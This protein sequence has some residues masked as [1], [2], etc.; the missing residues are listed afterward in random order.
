[1]S[2][3]KLDKLGREYINDLESRFPDYKER[4]AGEN[5]VEEVK[6]RTPNQQ[7]ILESSIECVEPFLYRIATSLL[8]GS[9][10][11]FKGK[12]LSL[13]GCPIDANDLVAVGVEAI[14]I[15][16]GRYNPDYAISTWISLCATPAMARYGCNNWGLVKIPGLDSNPNRLYPIKKLKIASYER[17]SKGEKFERL[18][19]LDLIIFGYQDLWANI[20]DSESSKIG[21]KG[22]KR[23][24]DLFESRI[25]D[26]GGVSPEDSA[27]NS[28]R[29][30]Q[31]RLILA[32]LTSIQEYVIRERFGFGGSERTLK[33]IGKDLGVSRERIR[34]IEQRALFKL[35]ESNRSKRLEQFID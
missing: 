21:E 35:K 13:K 28:E 14:L 5:W 32:T 22:T 20:D 8:N 27:S 7:R 10:N 15:R 16:M 34:Q 23:R 4:F 1:M 19:L 33:E 6:L 17:D 25:K 24:K 12:D 11:V 29:K 18:N 30:E 26:E 2:W 9:N 31:V 3:T